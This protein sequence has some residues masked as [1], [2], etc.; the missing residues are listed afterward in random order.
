M[1]S[2]TTEPPVHKLDI[3][4]S[5]PS[6]Y[7][8]PGILRVF[9]HAKGT[10]KSHTEGTTAKVSR[11]EHTKITAEKS[12]RPRTRTWNSRVWVDVFLVRLA[13]L[14]ISHRCC[15]RI[16]VDLIDILFPTAAVFCWPYGIAGVS[17]Q[18]TQ[19]QHK[20][21]REKTERPGL[22]PGSL[23]LRPP[24]QICLISNRF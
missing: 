24:L 22:A 3:F 5:L 1:L 20:K 12:R 23:T 14:Y 19:R 16:A 7:L 8:D 11:A 10:T 17:A 6:V 18:T 13:S 21:K 2:W 15:V 9:E 4:V